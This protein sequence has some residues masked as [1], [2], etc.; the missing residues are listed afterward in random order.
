MNKNPIS[1]FK[2]IF[3]ID[4]FPINF[5]RNIRMSSSSIIRREPSRELGEY[6]RFH[7]TWW[8][9]VVKNNEENT[10][11]IHRLNCIQSFVNLKMEII[12]MTSILSNNYVDTQTGSFR[13]VIWKHWKSADVLWKLKKQNGTSTAIDS[14]KCRFFKNLKINYTFWAFCNWDLLPKQGIFLSA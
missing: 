13:T 14:L 8:I 11:Q 5:V 10:G 9:Q 4:F 7:C 2:S 3:S 6:S 12:A 1:V